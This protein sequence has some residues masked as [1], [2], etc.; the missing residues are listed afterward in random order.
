MATR[1][2]VL[3]AT[4]V[5]VGLALGGVAY[6]QGHGWGPGGGW[7]QGSWVQGGWG[8]GGGRMGRMSE[9]DRAAFVDVRI[10]SLKAL[11]R[12]TAEQELLWPPFETAVRDVAR[13]R[14]ERTRDWREMR[15]GDARLDP[16]QRLRA[17]AD[18]ISAAGAS[19]A[20]VADAAGPLYAALD[21]SQRLRLGAAM[22]RIGRGM[23]G[24]GMGPPR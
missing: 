5:A 21:A 1:K 24:P 13:E 10:A 14:F 22:R 7:V 9:E 17:A 2:R 19:L 23:G 12:L 18:R 20:R 3:L 8:P 4:T 15:R 16:V 11:L 6:A